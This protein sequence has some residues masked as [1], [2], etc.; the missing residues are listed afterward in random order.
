MPD[1]ALCTPHETEEFT[2]SAANYDYSV[3]SKAKKQNPVGPS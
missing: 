3:H 1:L 2:N